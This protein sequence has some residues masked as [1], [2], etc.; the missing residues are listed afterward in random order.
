M[1]SAFFQFGTANALQSLFINLCLHLLKDPDQLVWST[2]AKI[3]LQRYVT[4]VEKTL[5]LTSTRFLET[6]HMQHVEFWHWLG[7]PL[8]SMLKREQRI[9]LRRSI[10]IYNKQMPQA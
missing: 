7:K 4:I 10:S 3:Q 8:S 5:L 2:I 9:A 1:N 6:V